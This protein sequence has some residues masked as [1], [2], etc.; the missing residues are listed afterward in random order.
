MGM[1]SPSRLLAGV[2]FAVALATSVVSKPIQIFHTGVWHGE[3]VSGGA[4]ARLAKEMTP[5][6]FAEARAETSPNG[7]RNVVDPR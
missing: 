4:L 2:V 5:E 1:T 7:P 3:E 6:Q